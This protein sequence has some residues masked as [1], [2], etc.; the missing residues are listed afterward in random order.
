[1]APSICSQDF[2]LLIIKIVLRASLP[3]VGTSAQSQLLLNP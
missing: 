1:M 3:V 2:A